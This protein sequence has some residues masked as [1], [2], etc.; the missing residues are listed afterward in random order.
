MAAPLSPMLSVN[1]RKHFSAAQ[2]AR[3]QLQVAAEFPP[4]FTVLF[5]PSGAGKS[6]LLDCL[7]G[8][9]QPDEGTIRLGE[10]VFFDAAKKISVSPHERAVGYVFQALALFPHLTVQ[11]NVAFGIAKLPAAEQQERIARIL[12]ILHIQQLTNRKPRELSGG[13]QQRVA[14]ARSLVTQPRLLLL[15][16]PLTGL[17]AGLRQSILQDLRE[18]NASNRVPIVYVTHNRDEVDAIGER[19]VALVDGHVRES[20]VPALVLDA[21][22]AAALAQAAGFENLLAG[23][24]TEKRPSDGVMRVAL[25]SDHCDLEVPLGSTELGAQ[26]QIAIRA[27]DIL[28][29]KEMPH[30]LSARNILSGS[31]QSLETRGTLVVA[32]VKAGAEFQVHVTPGA[33][34]SL[35]LKE[36]MAVWLVLKTHSCRVVTPR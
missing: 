1:I 14:L 8:L 15:D 27:G 12:R 23:R 35:E 32:H 34:R 4:G 2:S 20:G 22:S 25:E 28:L 10:S 13:E 26:I 9:L 33:A 7:A 24:I 29:A 3:F 36:G 21:P 30:G 19:V 17:D 31:I 16:E 11:D 6:T 5:G 18:W